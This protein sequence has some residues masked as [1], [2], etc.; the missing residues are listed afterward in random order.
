MI[1][2][3]RNCTSSSVLRV[4]RN[5]TSPFLV[6]EVRR[7]GISI[8]GK[9]KKNRRGS[10]FI[11]RRSKDKLGLWERRGSKMTRLYWL[12]RWVRYCHSVLT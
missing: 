10:Y 7:R 9:G 3:P 8:G 11:E 2:R 6:F 4:N 5:K 1:F 12:L